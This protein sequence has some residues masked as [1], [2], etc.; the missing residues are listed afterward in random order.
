LRVEALSIHPGGGAIIT[1][2]AAAR[3]GVRAGVLS[4]VSAIN[5][6]RL[7]QERVTLTNV[8]GAAERGAVSVALSTRRDRAFVTFDGVNRLIEPRL[9]ARLREVPEAARHVHFALVPRRC[10]AW[11]PVIGRLRSRGVTTS[12]DFGWSSTLPRD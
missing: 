11:I 12:W 1:A 7:R 3:L 8:R 9:I 2:V 6:A 4:A 5:E 10:A